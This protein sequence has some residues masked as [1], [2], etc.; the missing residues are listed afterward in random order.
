MEGRVK[1]DIF[2]SM[3]RLLQPTTRGIIAQS[4]MH[5]S[6]AIEH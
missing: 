6:Q 3:F 4:R 5:S 1:S 2:I